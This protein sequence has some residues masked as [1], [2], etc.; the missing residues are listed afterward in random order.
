MA[1]FQRLTHHIGIARTVE[2]IIC[3]TIGEFNNRRDDVFGFFRVDEMSHPEFLTPL[4][5]GVVDV[6]PNNHVGASHLRPLNDIEPDAAQPEYDNVIADLHFGGVCDRAHTGCDPTTDI[7][8][9]VEGGV[10]ADLCYGDFRQNRE[11]RKGRA[12]HIMINGLSLIGEPARSIRHQALALRRADRGTEIGLAGEAGF[13]LATFRRVERD[14][15]IARFDARHTRADLT[16]N[17]CTFM[18]EHARENAL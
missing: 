3:A 13:T 4:F 11:I 2:G 16:D 14:D 5:L 10:C 12:A 15:V 18:A 8:S 7:A 9:L 1:A 6:D 17:A